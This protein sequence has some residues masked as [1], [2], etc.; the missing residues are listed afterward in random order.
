MP[1][2]SRSARSTM[3]K[4]GVLAAAAVALAI[5]WWPSGPGDPM[6]LMLGRSP[7]EDA[8]AVRSCARATIQEAARRGMLLEI[9]TVGRPAQSRLEAIDMNA[10]AWSTKKTQAKRAEAL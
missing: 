5:W 6:I 7:S 10:K 2:K 8:A 1:V 4:L 9:G 3:L